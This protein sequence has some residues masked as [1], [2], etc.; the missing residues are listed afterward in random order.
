MS[1]FMIMRL[2]RVPVR[3]STVSTTFRSVC[4]TTCRSESRWFSPLWAVARRFRTPGTVQ[5]VRSGCDTDRP[6]SSSMRSS[7]CRTVGVTEQVSGGFRDGAAVVD[8]PIGVG[9]HAS[10]IR[11]QPIQPGQHSVGQRDGDVGFGDCRYPLPLD[12]TDSITG[13]RVDIDVVVAHCGARRGPGHTGRAAMAVEPRMQI[14]SPTDAPPGG[15]ALRS[16]RHRNAMQ[17]RTQRRTR[18]RQLK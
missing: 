2:W 9:Q 5:P 14:G 6:V 3:S 7:R 10:I 15:A 16:N 1:A 18:G 4:D 13:R 11:W 12:R 17:N 8:P